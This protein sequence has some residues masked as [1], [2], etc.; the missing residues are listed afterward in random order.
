MFS[1]IHKASFL[2]E[3]INNLSPVLGNWHHKSQTEA[4]PLLYHF[5]SLLL[6]WYIFNVTIPLKLP[7]ALFVDEVDKYADEIVEF[8]ED[9]TGFGNYFTYYD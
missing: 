9:E 5:L 2:E 7:V 3:V 8:I 4:L 6:G 1:H